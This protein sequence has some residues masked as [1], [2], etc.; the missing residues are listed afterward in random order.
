[1]EPR[2]IISINTKFFVDTRYCDESLD[3]TLNLRM[4]NATPRIF[5]HSIHCNLWISRI[6]GN[7]QQKKRRGSIHSI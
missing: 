6:I 3:E 7:S 2:L 4:R 5:I 1:M